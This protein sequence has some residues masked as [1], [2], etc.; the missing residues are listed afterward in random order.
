MA[1]KLTIKG[2]N[3]TLTYDKDIITTVNITVDTPP[4]SMAKSSSM[5]VTLHIAGSMISQEGSS[6]NSDVLEL[7]QWSLVPASNSDSYREV[8]VV[9][10]KADQASRQIV[11]SSAF[12]I[13]YAE[14]RSNQQGSGTFSLVLRQRSDRAG[15]VKVSHLPAT[16]Q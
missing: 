16:N 12:I 13:D 15:D 3:G 14:M 8:T 5:A 10:D 9:D 11:L 1:F 7:L 6:S 2:Q 4:N